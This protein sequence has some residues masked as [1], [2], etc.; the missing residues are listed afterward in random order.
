MKPLPLFIMW[1]IGLFFISLLCIKFNGS[2]IENELTQQTRQALANNAFGS[3]TSTLNGQTATLKG[4]A[5][6]NED[7]RQAE[8]L[9]K[10][11]NGVTDVNN[12][13][14]LTTPKKVNQPTPSLKIDHVTERST[15]AMPETKSD[16]TYPPQQLSIT[17]KPIENHIIN[18]PNVLATIPEN[19]HP[20]PSF[21]NNRMPFGNNNPFNMPFFGNNNSPWNN[22]FP[23]PPW[24]N[25]GFIPPMPNM[26]IAPIAP[27]APN[28]PFETFLPMPIQ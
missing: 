25:N 2:T 18:R 11:I 20:S 4:T 15:A 5:V 8:S 23:I 10:A 17:D 19:N 12:Q 3:V 7:R 14:I 21:N 22:S 1:L 24:G 27:T 6:S 13:L 26:P 9:V 16:S 28:F